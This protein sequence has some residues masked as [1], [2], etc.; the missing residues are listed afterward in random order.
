MRPDTLE[1]VETQAQ[2][3]RLTEIMHDLHG[4]LLIGEP[5]AIA[6][7]LAGAWA[8]VMIITGLYLWWP[9]GAGVAG[10][11]YPTA[12]RRRQDLAA[13]SARRHRLLAVA[14]RAVLPDLTRC[15]GPRSGARGS[16]PSAA[17]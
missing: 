10:L 8:I 6:V 15:P 2:K 14:L 7:E 1:V 16:K 3:S 5:G 9:R 4:E 12:L 17:S 11:L 13:R